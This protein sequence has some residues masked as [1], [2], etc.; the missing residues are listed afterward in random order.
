MFL[1]ILTKFYLIETANAKLLISNTSEL[2][3][4]FKF[5]CWYG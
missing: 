3:S 1:L 4:L 2:F 5:L